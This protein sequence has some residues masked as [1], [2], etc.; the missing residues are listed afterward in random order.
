MKT[1]ILIVSS[2]PSS[3]TDNVPLYFITNKKEI[4][5]WEYLS[6]VQI[7][8]LEHGSEFFIMCASFLPSLLSDTESFFAKWGSLEEGRQM[9]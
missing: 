5:S 6:V 4:S 8:I 9:N 2:F 7:F 3:L 1:E